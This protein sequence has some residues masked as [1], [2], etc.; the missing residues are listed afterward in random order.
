[1]FYPGSAKNLTERKYSVV[2]QTSNCTVY[3][4]NSN[5]CILELSIIKLDLFILSLVFGSS[6][7]T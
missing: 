1:M 5:K 6:E 2:V 7:F 3:I 4:K